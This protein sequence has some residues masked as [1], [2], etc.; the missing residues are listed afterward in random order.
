MPWLMVFIFSFLPYFFWILKS[1]KIKVVSKMKCN[2]NVFERLRTTLSEMDVFGAILICG[3][4][5]Y[6]YASSASDTKK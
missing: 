1:T 2:K 6:H 3:S 5:S 4:S